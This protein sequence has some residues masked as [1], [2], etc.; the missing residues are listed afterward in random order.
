MKDWQSICLSDSEGWNDVWNENVRFATL[1][2][3]QQVNLQSI[4]HT[5]QSKAEEDVWLVYPWKM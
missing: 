3:N 2:D 4:V 1:T 5:H